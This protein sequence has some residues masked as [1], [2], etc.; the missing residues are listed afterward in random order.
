MCIK[1]SAKPRKIYFDPGMAS[2]NII[3]SEAKEDNN[4]AWEREL[5]R[6]RVV[7]ESVS[8]AYAAGVRGV[9]MRALEAPQRQFAIVTRAMQAAAVVKKRVSPRVAAAGTVYLSEVSSGGAV[10]NYFSDKNTMIRRRGAVTLAR[11]VRGALAR[12][13]AAAY[14]TAA[15]KVVWFF[16]LVQKKRF[17]VTKVLAE[18][19]E[20]NANPAKM[21]QE[22]WE[23]RVHLPEVVGA[24]R[25]LTR[26]LSCVCKASI[27]EV[28]KARFDENRGGGVRLSLDMMMREREEALFAPAGCADMMA[29]CDAVF[30]RQ[31]HLRLLHTCDEWPE[32]FGESFLYSEYTEEGCVENCGVKVDN[33][34]NDATT[35]GELVHAVEALGRTPDRFAIMKPWQRRELIK[36]SKQVVRCYNQVVYELSTAV[37]ALLEISRAAKES[38]EEAR[39]KAG[40]GE[41]AKKRPFKV[42]IRTALAYEVAVAAYNDL[43]RRQNHFY[44]CDGGGIEAVVE[45][46]WFQGELDRLMVTLPLSLDGILKRMRVVITAK[47]ALLTCKRED[48]PKLQKDAIDSQEKK[49]GKLVMVMSK[50]LGELLEIL[51]GAPMPAPLLH[52]LQLVM[53]VT[54][55]STSTKETRLA[56]LSIVKVLIEH[57]RALVA[58]YPHNVG[59]VTKAYP[60]VNACD[61]IEKVFDDAASHIHA[62]MVASDS[63]STDPVLDARA[64]TKELAAIASNSRLLQRKDTVPPPLLVLPVL[65]LGTHRADGWTVTL[66][67][68]RRKHPTVVQ[69][70]LIEAIEVRRPYFAAALFDTPHAHTAGDEGGGRIR[71]GQARDGARMEKQALYDAH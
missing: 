66:M 63:V 49:L 41:V 29:A 44:H 45:K 62:A 8:A 48:A 12:K 11:F 24:L 23:H 61:N 16:R 32:L 10:L 9:A 53:A 26:M 55:S 34:N 17:G 46:W 60:K 69:R 22:Q 50:M 14:A 20:K 52:R 67:H 4:T 57:G 1:G 68:L 42:C 18:L 3:P 21:S 19:R 43:W 5:K 47:K 31:R 15:I 2:K 37:P 28:I 7:L 65:D 13:T 58:T 36:V 25:G 59:M 70:T 51:G 39:K 35:K 64:I 40:G 6:R 38:H 33:N 27:S 30:E 56:S 54:L 71:Q